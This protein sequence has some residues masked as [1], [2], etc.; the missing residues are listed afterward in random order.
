MRATAAKL[1]VSLVGARARGLDET[2]CKVLPLKEYHPIQRN[3]NTPC[4]FSPRKAISPPTVGGGG[5]NANKTL[6]F[7]LL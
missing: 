5:N 6:C 1:V 3:T 2:E 7:H 4:Q